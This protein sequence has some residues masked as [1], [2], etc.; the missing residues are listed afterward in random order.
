M[1]IDLSRGLYSAIIKKLPRHLRSVEDYYFLSFTVPAI[2]CLVLTSPL[3]AYAGLWRPAWSAALCALTISGLLA[4]WR[5]G[6]SIPWLQSFFQATLLSIILYNAYYTGGV[7]SPV[8]VWIGIVPIL[9]LFTVSRRWSY[10]WLVISFVFVVTVYVAQI[11][12][13]IPLNI[14]ITQQELTLSA[15]MIG[16]L[17]ITQVM[18]VTTYDSANAQHIRSIERNNSTLKNLSQDLQQ[19]HEHKDKFLATVSHEMRTPLNALMGYLGLLRTTDQLPAVASSYVQGAQNSAAHLLTVINDLLD[20]SQIQQGKLVLSPQTVNLAQVLKETH[21]TLAPRA[22]EQALN[23]SLQ[24]EDNLPQW[25]RTDPH[26]LTQ[27][28]LNLLGNALKFTHHG[29]VTTQV[30][31][32][33]DLHDAQSGTV[34]LIVHDTGMGIPSEYFQRIFEPFVQVQGQNNM[35][36]DNALRGNGLGLSITK[37]LIVNLGGTIT[38]DSQLGVGSTFEVRLPIKIA[39]APQT[40]KVTHVTEVYA[41]KIYLLLVDDHATNR[42]VTSATIKRDLPNAIIDEAR[43][44][45]EAIQKMKAN[46]YDLVLMDLIMPDYSGV[47]VTRIIRT[48]CAPPLS[49]VHVVALTANVAEAAI[50][51]CLEVGISEVLRKPFDRDVM[52]RTILQHAT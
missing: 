22:A 31:F 48:E 39:K 6:V 24:L 17:C 49:Q 13:L 9:P 38:L 45:T 40:K 12:G 15:L 19:A 52:I 27:I 29:S 51:D 8:M 41:E 1:A 43:N 26:R 50:K 14:G 30:R 36:N 37:N 4:L 5:A 25:V 28:F 44:G 47:E 23:F 46:A 34:I 11:Q 32:E 42:L 35:G 16:L 7:A 20:F 18:L 3:L 21:D 33:P 2:V 10:V